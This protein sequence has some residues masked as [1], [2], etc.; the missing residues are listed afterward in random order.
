MPVVLGRRILISLA[1]T[2]GAAVRSKGRLAYRHKFS[3]DSGLNMLEGSNLIVDKINWRVI[4]L[5]R[6]L[7]L[8]LVLTL[9]PGA[10]A[11]FRSQQP[12]Q[13]PG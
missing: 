6:R 7:D 2:G 11:L 3:N 9:L 8:D 13:F 1:V 5:G 4:T 12:N 10:S